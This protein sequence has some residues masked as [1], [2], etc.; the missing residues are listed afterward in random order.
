MLSP[1]TPLAKVKVHRTKYIFAFT[2]LFTFVRV[3]R[4]G[5]SIAAS[6]GQVVVAF[7]YLLTSCYGLYTYARSRFKC[8]HAFDRV[9]VL[10]LCWQLSCNSM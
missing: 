3:K 8:N 1:L 6:C 10:Y 9:P 2:S 4:S 5:K 7:R